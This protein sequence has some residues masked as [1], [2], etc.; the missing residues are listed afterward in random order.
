MKVAELMTPEPQTIAPDDSVRHAA[1]LMDRLDVGVL[2][3]CEGQRLVGVVT[4]RD[5]TIRSTAVGSPPDSTSIREVMTDDVRWVNKDDDSADAEELMC[6]MQVR[7]V[8]VIDADKRL[9]GIL[10]LGDL[11]VAGERGVK[12]TL[13]II[14]QPGHPER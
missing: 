4:D 7:R 11:A 14:S 9:V 5:I 10:A 8:P 13:E 1:E 12:E 6:K 3:V 2:P